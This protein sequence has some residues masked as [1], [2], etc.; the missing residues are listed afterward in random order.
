MNTVNILFQIDPG[1]FS[2]SDFLPVF[3][4]THVFVD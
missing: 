3:H 2:V 4:K 1:K